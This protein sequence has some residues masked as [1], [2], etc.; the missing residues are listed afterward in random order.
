MA[1]W[2]FMLLIDPDI[3]FDW[4]LRLVTKC[5]SSSIWLEIPMVGV[6]AG[7]LVMASPG[8]DTSSGSDINLF[9]L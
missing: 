4:D 9:E 8:V 7:F 2:Q 1:S 5:Q 6:I 3:A